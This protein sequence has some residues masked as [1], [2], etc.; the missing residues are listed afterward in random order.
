MK[1]FPPTVNIHIVKQCNYKCRFCF[2]H[3]HETTNSLRPDDWAN[4][5]KQLL[6]NGARKINFAGGEPTLYKHL[7]RLIELVQAEGG[8]ASVVTNGTGL[9][10]L[11]RECRPDIIGL[12]VDSSSDA[13]NSLLGRGNGKHASQIRKLAELAHEAGSRLKINTVVTRPILNED[14]TEFIA[15]LKPE[16]WKLFQVL[17]IRGENDDQIE[18]LL[19]SR[20]EFE[21]F[22]ERHRH[23]ERH[24][25]LVVPENNE[26]MTGSYAMIDPDGRFFDNTSG[27]LRY[28]DP[29]MIVGVQNAWTQV[30]FCRDRFDQRGG[31]Y[32]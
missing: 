9:V 3:F 1:L 16:R 25:T 21:S 17:P 22:V 28:S 30:Q 6:A 5:C 27:E 29:I 26:S 7:A 23:I 18:E 19:V 10:R 32:E 11:L 2:A 15:T 14:M 8:V 31:D 20:E 12:S 13:V 4:I 24:G